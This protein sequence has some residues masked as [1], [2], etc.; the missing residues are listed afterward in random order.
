MHSER[1]PFPDY[2]LY[3][4]QLRIDRRKSLSGVGAFTLTPIR[5]G[6]QEASDM[7][8]LIAKLTVLPGRRDEIIGILKRMFTSSF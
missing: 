7:W 8:G 4:R 5:A 3:I 2:N 1:V 6:S